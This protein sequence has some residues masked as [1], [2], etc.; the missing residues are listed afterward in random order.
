MELDGAVVAALPRAA[1]VVED[2]YPKIFDQEWVRPAVVADGL[3]ELQV[4]WP[5]VPIVVCDNRKT[6][7]EWTYRW[8][9]AAHTWASQ[10]QAAVARIGP[11]ALELPGTA[12]LRAWAQEH[13][14]AVA[15]RGRLRPEIARAWRDAHTT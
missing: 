8:L 3:A 14:L 9:A 15:D 13:G 7:E 6:A 4:S 5:G 1:V 2:R 12:A 11:A 10:E